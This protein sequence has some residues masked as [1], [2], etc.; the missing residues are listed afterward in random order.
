MDPAVDLAVRGGLAT[1]WVAAAAHKAVDL[2]RFRATLAAYAVLPAPLVGPATVLVPGVELATA[3]CLVAARAAGLVATAALLFAYAGALAVNLVRGR[4][5]LDCGC[6]GTAGR[7]RIS[8]ALVAR[9]LV[10]AGVAAA[11]AGPPA[12]R[13]WTWVDGLTVGGAVAT[14]AALYLASDGLLA[15]RPGVARIREA[16]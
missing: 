10:L 12:A 14:G 13:A 7:E 8:W 3:A 16:A 9:N 15:N 4:R 11:S 5:D 2:D 1:L 6:L